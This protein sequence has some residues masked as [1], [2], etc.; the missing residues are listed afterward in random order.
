MEETHIIERPLYMT[1][2][3]PFIGKNIIKVLTGQRRVGKSYILKSV[4][5]HIQTADP[6]ANIISIDL[7]DFAF[8]HI[9]DAKGLHD[10][11]IQHIKAGV[12]N[13]IFID[14]VQ[15]IKEFERVLRSLNQNPANDIYVTGSNSE[16]LSSEMASKLAGR[17]FEM[18]IHPLSYPEYLNFHK[19]EDSDLTMTDYL[20]YG[21][22]PYLVNLPKT[23]TWNEYLSGITDAVVYRDIV[24][25]H[26]LRNNDFLQRLLLFL[27]DNI[28]QIFTA[29]KIADYLKSQRISSSVGSVL[30]YVGYTEEAYI[31][32]KSRRW[33]IE[34]KKFFEIGEKYF[35]EDL[36]IRNSIVGFRPHDIS[37]LMENAVYNHLRCNGYKVKTGVLANGREIDFIA[38]KDNENLYVQVAM[39]VTD[40]STADRE[41]GNLLTIPD[42]Y[43]KIVVTYKESFPNTMQGIRT[44]TL[45]EF[46]TTVR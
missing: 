33:D 29:K 36:G 8:S 42:N 26:S 43:E 25:R 32:N 31:I 44:M 7:E 18:Q 13:Y 10:E 14:E 1:R 35:F 34:G 22:L 20:R 41:Y 40:K 12:K 39:T 11:I 24:T 28:G 38:Q 16:M 21:G 15:E 2:L 37:G 4:A 23:N 27:A 5:E 46:M 19:V 3:F 6:Q 17:S 45:R 9:T 30:S